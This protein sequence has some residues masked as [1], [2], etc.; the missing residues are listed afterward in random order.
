M[1]VAAC[2]WA[3]EHRLVRVGL[4]GHE[5]PNDQ[6]P[7]SNLVFLIDVSGSMNM[8]N[9]LPLLQQC[10]S[11]LVEQLGPKDRVAI[12]TYAGRTGV[13]LE[14][15][16]DREA[17]QAVVDRLHAGGSTN[18]ASGV[19]LA[20]QMAEKNFIKGGTNRVILATDGDWNVGITNQSQLLDMIAEKAKSGVFLT[21]L[22][23]G[24]DNL[25]DSML[26]KLADRGNGHYAYIDTPLE[27]KKVFVEQLSGTLVTIAKDVKIQVEFNPAQ[28]GAYRLIG[29][30]KRMLAKEDFNNDKKDA[31]EIGAGHTVTALYEVEPAGKEQPEIV[32]VDKLKYQPQTELLREDE[33]V[34]R[35]S[36]GAQKAAPAAPAAPA[37]EAAAPAPV[38]L[39]LAKPESAPI[40]HAIPVE[41]PGLLSARVPT[42][43][44]KSEPT[45]DPAG[46][47]APVVTD[48]APAPR[49]TSEPTAAPHA[50]RKT[51]IVDTNRYVRSERPITNIRD[52]VPAALS[53]EL[54][55]L[56]L[57]YKAPDGD[58]SK[59]LEF[60]LTDHGA[61]WEKSSPDF[62]FA[63]A[64]A[65]YGML[66]RD[67]SYRGEATWQSTAKWAHEG[68][69]ADK[70]GYRAEFLN[71][72]D[73]AKALKQ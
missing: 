60:P 49:P 27:A 57:R 20:Y 55:T 48:S 54:L 16:Q 17:V 5:V 4:K 73:K 37:L 70:S 24:M 71:L 6:R 34:Q 26:V 2:P 39:R 31:G 58:K 43:A 67:S 66:L 56:K 53:H 9:K 63:A 29:Y 8:P 11:L 19:Q 21:V 32:M 46:G 65:S 42:P 18:G 59:L 38:P 35:K 30:E 23:F 10:F 28:V 33:Q 64:V 61:T 40:P 41:K 22:G 25:K 14:S 15:T 3:P 36:E 13:A 69:G 47:G 50:T 51:I 62:R 72:L 45:S 44:V 7:P 1:E 12:V 68:L 52:A